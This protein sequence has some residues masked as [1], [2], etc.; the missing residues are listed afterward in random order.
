MQIT[1]R[2]YLSSSL[3]TIY[4]IFALDSGNNDSSVTNNE[5]LNQIPTVIG[6][7]SFLRG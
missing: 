2:N 6:L 1:A 7:L 4:E 3:N 5:D